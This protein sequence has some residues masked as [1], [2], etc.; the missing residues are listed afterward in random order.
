MRFAIRPVL[1]FRAIREVLGLH[2]LVNEPIEFL[3]DPAVQ[4]IPGHPRDYH[5]A[6]RALAEDQDPEHEMQRQLCNYAVRAPA[7]ALIAT[8]M[9]CAITNLIGY[10][11]DS[12]ASM[13]AEM[14]FY[15]ASTWY[16]V[17]AFIT[18]LYLS[19][20]RRHMR[21]IQVMSILVF[22]AWFFKT[23]VEWSGE[24]ML[25]RTVGLQG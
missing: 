10:H 6:A 18:I 19:A 4:D 1:S 9:E 22:A 15:I 13:W 2:E 8:A 23:M 24:A 7:F 21:C 11:P 20:C 12:R 16:G 14:L 17:T 3:R 25:N 5:A